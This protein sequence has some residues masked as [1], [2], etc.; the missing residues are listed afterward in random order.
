MD[1]KSLV[2]FIQSKKQDLKKHKALF[3]IYEGNLNKHLDE[4]LRKQIKGESVYYAQVRKCPINILR[5]FVDK[6]SQIYQTNPTRRPVNGSDVDMRLLEYYEKNMKI[7][8]NMNL[9]NE[10]FNM[11]RSTLIQPYAHKGIPRLRAVPNDRFIVYSDDEVDPLNVTKV[12]II[13]DCEIKSGGLKNN[14]YHV[15]TDEEFYI[16]DDNEK[17]RFDKMADLENEDGI[18]PF[19]K[20]PFVYVNRSANLIMPPPDEE[21]AQLV[22]L[23]AGL[24]TDLNFASMFSLFSIMYGID[25]DDQEIQLSPNAFW[26]LKSDPSTDKTPSLGTLK[27]EADVAETL[28]LIKTQV[29]MFLTSRSVKVSAIGDL[30]T[31]NFASGISKLLDESDTSEERSRQISYFQEAEQDLWNLITKYMHPVWTSANMLDTRLSFSPN[32]EISTEF[33]EPIPMF[34]RGELARDLRDEVDA[35]FLSKKRAIKLLNPDK[36]S[37]EIEDILLE[38]ESDQLVDISGEVGI[39][40]TEG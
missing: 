31:S 29:A 23:V 33:Q 8:M 27:N 1:A 7:D 26:H 12:I 10:F 37:E 3:E 5:K 19:G 30:E 28:E 9:A 38:L 17:I 4:W 24:M 18:N 35:G 16:L 34:R 11:S 14:I 32:V 13:A 2:N 40:P 20:I 39:G 15:Y 25:L 6:L 36:S 21:L 22:I